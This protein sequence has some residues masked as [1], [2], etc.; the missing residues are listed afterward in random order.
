V[1]DTL[2]SYAY[3]NAALKTYGRSGIVGTVWKWTSVNA[4]TWFRFYGKQLEL[5]VR[6][7]AAA[8]VQISI[9]N[10][11]FTNVTTTTAATPAWTTAWSGSEGWHTA[12]ILLPVGYGSS[13]TSFDTGA[14]LR[15]TGTDGNEQLDTHPW[16]GDYERLGEAPFATY[17]IKTHPQTYNSFGDP[18]GYVSPSGFQAL[19]TFT[20]RNQSIR[21]KATWVEGSRL[22]IWSMETSGIVA[23]LKI[24]NAMWGNST[25][26]YGR[27]SGT[28][29][30]IYFDLPGSGSHE[31]EVLNVTIADAI[32][33]SDG[34]GGTASFFVDEAVEAKSNL[35]VMIGDSQTRGA[36]SGSHA[37]TLDGLLTC[38]AN[39]NTINLGVDGNNLS[40][41]TARVASQ[42]TP[43]S[44]NVVIVHGGYNP[45]K[46]EFNVLDLSPWPLLAPAYIAFL[47]EV[48]A[49]MPSLDYIFC[50]HVNDS[51]NDFVARNAAIDSGIA[52]F[53]SSHPSWVGKVITITNDPSGVTTDAVSGHISSIGYC[54]IHGEA[55][56][57]AELTAQPADGD[58]VT[59]TSADATKVFEFDN[60]A[61]IT[62]GNV[63]VT[64]GATTAETNLN[65]WKAIIAEVDLGWDVRPLA[66]VSDF[67]FGAAVMDLTAISKSGTNIT[68]TGPFSSGFATTVKSYLGEW[69]T[70]IGV[71]L[72]LLRQMDGGYSLP[73]SMNGGYSA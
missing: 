38:V 20:G 53:L 56:G 61:T 31:L 43:H 19:N 32:M 30:F 51:W 35:V 69:P 3:N 72:K 68:V 40:S 10:G 5:Q 13:G 37:N 8:G 60:N 12:V 70:D 62:P 7:A 11:S 33:I 16:S 24:D 64:I 2:T 17:G 63:A 18:Q 25:T 58:T 59:M 44:P 26:V 4:S 1:A 6:S 67:T 36:G 47:E 22:F 54:Q 66:H 49:E 48:I 21:R 50:V 52:S 28:R 27:P 29:G 42:I 23:T 71:S 46:D 9:D 65:F 14:M 45:E 41:M 15:V 39:T 34:L 55:T 73:R 57:V